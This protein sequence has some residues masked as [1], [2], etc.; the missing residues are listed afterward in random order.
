MQYYWARGKPEVL[1]AVECT[2]TYSVAV[3]QCSFKKA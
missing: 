3:L 1:G 2:V